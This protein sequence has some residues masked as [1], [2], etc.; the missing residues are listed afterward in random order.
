MFVRFGAER[1]VRDAAAVVADESSLTALPEVDRG[2]RCLAVRGRAQEPSSVGASQM[3]VP[4]LEQRVGPLILTVQIEHLIGTGLP[5]CCRRP[6]P[7]FGQHSMPRACVFD[8]PACC[9]RQVPSAY[10]MISDGCDSSGPHDALSGAHAPTGR[11]RPT[12]PPTGCST[13]TAVTRR[14]DDQLAR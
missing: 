2:V 4:F 9:D 1:P 3:T 11:R 10:R 5:K 14:V 13:S 6:P 12:G 7:H 8:G